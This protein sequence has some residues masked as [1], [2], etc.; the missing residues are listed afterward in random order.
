MLCSCK[1]ILCLVD[2]VIKIV[3]WKG[4][5]SAVKV[6]LKCSVKWPGAVANVC[7]P[8]YS[9]GRDQ[10]DC[11]LR[12]SPGKKVRLSSLNKQVWGSGMYLFS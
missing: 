7:N 5:M 9:G 12:P 10:E 6:T 8:S 11:S 3:G 4:L 2:N 1:T